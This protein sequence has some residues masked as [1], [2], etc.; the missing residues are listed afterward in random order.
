MIYKISKPLAN[1]FFFLE[2]QNLNLK[3]SVEILPGDIK[4]ILHFNE[5]TNESI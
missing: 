4:F 1:L 3:N 2:I 5:I